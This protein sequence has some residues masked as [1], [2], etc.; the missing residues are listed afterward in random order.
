MLFRSVGAGKGEWNIGPTETSQMTDIRIYN[1]INNGN[2][3]STY[4][5]DDPSYLERIGIGGI[6]GQTGEYD[7]TLG[8]PGGTQ[9]LTI[10]GNTNNGIISGPDGANVGSIIGITDTGRNS[11]GGTVTIGDNWSSTD[12]V[13][14]GKDWGNDRYESTT[15]E[16]YDP[17]THEVVGGKLVEKKIEEEP[18]KPDSG[19]QN[20]LDYSDYFDNTNRQQDPERPLT[21]SNPGV[22][23]T[24]IPELPIPSAPNPTYPVTGNNTPSLPEATDFE[25]NNPVTRQYVPIGNASQS[26]EPI[27]LQIDDTETPL[28]SDLTQNESSTQDDSTP[29]EDA[30]P[31][32]EAPNDVTAPLTTDVI[33][34]PAG[35]NPALIIIPL[36][37]LIIIIAAIGF[38]NF[39]KRTNAA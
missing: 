5:G 30:P 35:I 21:Q 39:K 18:K 33:I 36:L 1:S 2:V 23:D 10:E 3:Q 7:W 8:N 34:D 9:N 4:N 27:I 13:G 25:R 11:S 26:T 15:G 19:Q 12:P 24:T 38:I 37:A 20:E 29:P 22:N 31:P 14:G 6:I 16:K 17:V 28:A 32:Q